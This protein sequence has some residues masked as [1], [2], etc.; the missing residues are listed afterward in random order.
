MLPDRYISELCYLHRYLSKLCY[1]HRHLNKFHTNKLSHT[2]QYQE[3]QGRAIE[4]PYITQKWCISPESQHVSPSA[5]QIF[6]IFHLTEGATHV[7]YKT[8]DIGPGL[9]FS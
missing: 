3:Q 1:L 6:T 4:T 8:S 9:T 2:K 5:G 7:Y